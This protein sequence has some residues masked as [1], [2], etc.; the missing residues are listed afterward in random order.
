MTTKRDPSLNYSHL[1][2]ECRGCP[3]EVIDHRRTVREALRTAA[4]TCDLRI[5]QEAVHRFRP[6]GVTA[7]ALLRE[8]HISVHTWPEN[9]FAVIDVLSCIGINREGLLVCFKRLFKPR[10]ITVRQGFR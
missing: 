8:S 10:R 7:Y 4:E 1:I 5:L 3:S 6:Q 9:G 2:V